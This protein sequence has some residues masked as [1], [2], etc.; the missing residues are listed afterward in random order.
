LCSVKTI[1]KKTEE[2]KI[3]ENVRTVSMGR[4]GDERAIV[5]GLDVSVTSNLNGD[6]A[7]DLREAFDRAP[8]S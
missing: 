2:I 5:E 4:T 8:V 6:R 7:D 3:K 1:E